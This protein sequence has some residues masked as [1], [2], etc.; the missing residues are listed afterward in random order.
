MSEQARCSIC[1][2]PISNVTRPGEADEVWKH[3][4]D[5]LDLDHAA[6]FDGDVCDVQ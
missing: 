6:Q 2:E 5:N 1:G 4:D 3:H